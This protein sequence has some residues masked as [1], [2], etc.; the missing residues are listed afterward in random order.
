MSEF[1]YEKQ[2]NIKLTQSLGGRGDFI[3][4]NPSTAAGSYAHGGI[5]GYGIGANNNESFDLEIM[6]PP[7]IEAIESDISNKI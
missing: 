4:K 6:M 2:G 5:G 1:N 7:D 3:S